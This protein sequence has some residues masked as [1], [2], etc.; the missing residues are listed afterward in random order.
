MTTGMTRRTFITTAALAVASLPLAL[1]GGAAARKRPNIIWILADDLGY[2]DLGCYGCADIPTPN[3]DGMAARGVRCDHFYAAAPVCSPSRACLL[4]G[5]YPEAIGVTEVLMGSG[6]M[7]AGIVTIAQML[8]KSGYATG[9]VGKWHLGYEGDS[10]PNNRGFDEFYGFRGGKIDYFAHTDTAQKDDNN[11]MGRHDFY[12]NGAEIFPKGYST[13]LFTARAMKFVEAHKRDSFFLFLSYNA[14]HY[15]RP[16]VL[17]A[18]EKYIAKF[19]KGKEATLRELY[20]AMVNCMDDGVGDLLACLKKNNLDQ[21]TIVMFLSDNGADRKNGGSNAPLSGGKWAHT[22]GGIRVPMI[23][24]WPGVLP[25]A[26]TCGEVL[27]M[28]DLFPTM[29]AAAETVPPKALQLDGLNVLDV[30][31]GRSNVP[32]R[33]LLFGKKTVRKGKWKLNGA[34]LYDLSNDPLEKRDCATEN[35]EVVKEL[36]QS[37]P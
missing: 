37:R 32:E 9:L 28:M 19:A 14:P 35:S 18:P 26:K 31:Q 15:A 22:E 23:A 36:Q 25:A 3:I 33:T 13:D 24:Q 30:L 12:D 17:Q 16:Q 2:G 6:G 10:L 27:H 20:A 11:P 34:N 21:D 7:N 8:K 1:R 5:R 4:T 29:L